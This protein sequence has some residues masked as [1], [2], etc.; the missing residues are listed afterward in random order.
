[1]PRSHDFIETYDG[2]VGFGLDRKTDEDTLAYYLQAFSEDTL[3]ATL[4]P[5]MTGTELED[6]FARLS[7]LLRRHLSEPEYHRLF[8]LEEHPE[9]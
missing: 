8:L 9:V 7:T 6:L 1:M 3:L 5:R 2:L 4:L